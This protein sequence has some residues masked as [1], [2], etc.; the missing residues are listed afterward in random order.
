MWAMMEKLRMRAWEIGMAGGPSGVV[1]RG[2]RALRLA[3]TLASTTR[4]ALWRWL[5]GGW[6]VR[7]LGQVL[8]PWWLRRS[9]GTVLRLRRCQRK[10][11]RKKMVVLTEHQIDP[12]SDVDRHGDFRALVQQP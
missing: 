4:G 5:G 12:L 2:R 7:R 9:R 11:T 1:L 8:A 6:G 3:S 10:L